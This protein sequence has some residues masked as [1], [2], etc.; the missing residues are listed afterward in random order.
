MI[1]YRSISDV[2][3]ALDPP[4]VF[5]NCSKNSSLVRHIIIRKSARLSGVLPLMTS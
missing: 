4:L 5:H 3:A 1:L 2:A